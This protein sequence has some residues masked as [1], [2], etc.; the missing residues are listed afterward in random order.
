MS[1]CQ[2]FI[3]M[4]FLI[5]PFTPYQEP[6]RKKHWTEILEEERLYYQ[7]YEEQRKLQEQKVVEESLEANKNPFTKDARTFLLAKDDGDLPSPASPHG[8]G[9]NEYAFFNPNITLGFTSSVVTGKVP[10]SVQFV[11][12]EQGTIQF[13][14]YRW[15]FGDGQ[16]STQVAPKHTYSVPGVYDVV[17]TGSA[18]SNPGIVSF[19]RIFNYISASA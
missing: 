17:L 12:L 13:I 11:N 8:S 16:T 19:L 14:D 2:I 18:H 5:E 4:A 1:Y 3:D 6:P 7:I 10:F 9:V 15:N